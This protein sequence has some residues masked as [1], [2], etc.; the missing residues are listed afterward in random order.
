MLNLLQNSLE[1]I[2]T[3][4]GHVNFGL[5]VV[6]G[7]KVIVAL[8]EREREKDKE[9]LN[10]VQEILRQNFFYSFD[11]PFNTARKIEQNS[12]ALE[13]TQRIPCGIGTILGLQYAI[14]HLLSPHSTFWMGGGV[15]RKTEGQRLSKGD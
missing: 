15:E 2:N 6:R 12:V 14:K 8:A 4:I 13:N 10:E 7:H 9:N 3:G 11:V 5:L 1:N